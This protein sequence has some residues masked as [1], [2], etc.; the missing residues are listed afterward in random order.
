MRGSRNQERKDKA[1]LDRSDERV[2]AGETV[3][4][5]DIPKRTAISHE[6]N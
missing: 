2:L 3:V 6:L 4:L 1:L 5:V